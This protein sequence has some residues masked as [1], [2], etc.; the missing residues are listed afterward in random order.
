MTDFELRTMAEMPPRR[1][2]GGVK[3]GGL[4]DAIRNLKAGQTIFVPANGR[5]V[6]TV[7]SGLSGLIMQA[8]RRGQVG[9]R[10]AE[11]GVWIY[12]KGDDAL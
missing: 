6:A 4:T 2:G 12:T 3:R 9:R 11:D 8:G 7:A 5:E 1:H 10:V